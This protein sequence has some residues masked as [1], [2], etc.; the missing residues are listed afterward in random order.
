MSALTAGQGC[1]VSQ[2]LINLLEEAREFHPTK[3]AAS[4]GDRLDTLEVEAL[5]QSAPGATLVM[6]RVA[7]E[8]IEFAERIAT[9]SR[10]S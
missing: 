1:S 5:E 6:I 2:K 3:Q 4:F 7:R 9:R 10:R 8:A